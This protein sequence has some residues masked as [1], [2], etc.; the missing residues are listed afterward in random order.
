[1][2]KT[3]SFFGVPTKTGIQATTRPTNLLPIATTIIKTSK[4]KLTT[5]APTLSASLT[6]KYAT[7]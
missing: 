7:S 6:T 1:M 3:N 5:I 4:R 2:N